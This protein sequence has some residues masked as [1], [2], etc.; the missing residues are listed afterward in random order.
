MMNWKGCGRKRSLPNVRY[1]PRICLEKLSEPRKM[2]VRTAGC[3]CRGLNRILLAY[4]TEVLA[5][6][7]VF[8]VIL[9]GVWFHTRRTSFD[10]DLR[11]G[12]R[13]LRTNIA[14]SANRELE[15]I[16]VTSRSSK[17]AYFS[18]EWKRRLQCHTFMQWCNEVISAQRSSL[19]L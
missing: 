19:W 18:G 14:V 10:N 17:A 1:Y 13:H 3:S 7:P 5:S 2:S 15:L 16:S 8:S 9:G 11:G 4:K 6:K 12:G